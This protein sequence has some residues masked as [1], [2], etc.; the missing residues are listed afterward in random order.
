MTAALRRSTLSHDGSRLYAS[1]RGHDSVATLRSRSVHRPRDTARL[2]GYPG[3]DATVFCHGARR[4][5]FL[6]VADE[7][8]DRIV[9]FVAGGQLL[10]AGEPV[11]TGSPVCIVF[12]P[13]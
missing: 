3:E 12:A 6:F 5:R 1:N 2:G 11:G 13:G 9:P 4:A 10:P 7:D 8:S